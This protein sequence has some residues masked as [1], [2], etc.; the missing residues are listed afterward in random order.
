[1]SKQ[2]EIVLLAAFK[3]LQK[4]DRTF[5]LQLARAL[6]ARAS[7]DIPLPKVLFAGDGE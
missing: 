1:M 7:N 3:K 5:L 4:R 6:K 2:E